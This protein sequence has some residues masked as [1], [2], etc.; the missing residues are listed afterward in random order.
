MASG[1]NE[2]ETCQMKFDFGI[3]LGLV[4]IMEA[5]CLSAISVVGLLAYIGVS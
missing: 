4:L 5:A 2:V 3:R 1:Q